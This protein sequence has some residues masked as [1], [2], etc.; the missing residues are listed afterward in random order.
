MESFFRPF[1]VGRKQVR[2]VVDAGCKRL[3][4][5]EIARDQGGCYRTEIVGVSGQSLCEGDLPGR[6]G[7]AV[8]LRRGFRHQVRCHLAWLGYPIL[9]DPLYDCDNEPMDGILAL[10]AGGLFFCDPESGRPLEYRI[11]ALE[12]TANSM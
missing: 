4:R 2:P 11:P 12:L 7:F 9:N 5:R 1:G 3:M 8:R 10:R 6:F